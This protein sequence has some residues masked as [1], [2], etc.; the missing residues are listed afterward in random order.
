[1]SLEVGLSTL[2]LIVFVSGVFSS[3][4]ARRCAGMIAAAGLLVLIAA[5]FLLPPAGP[6]AGGVFVDDGLA[7]FAKRLFLVSTFIGVLASLSLAAE[8]FSRR[9]TEYYLLM[10]SSLLGMMVLASARDLI[11][12]FV[13][14][15]LMS[16][17]LY[18][19][20]G[21]LK[22]EPE[23]IEAALKFFLVG[24]VSSAVMAYGLSFVYGIAGTT[25][26]PGVA[27]ALGSE[28]PLLVFGLAAVLAGFGFK[29][30]AFPFHMWVPDTYEAASTPFVAWLS[31]APKAA[32]FVAIF[33]VYLEGVG[34]RAT[35]WL[36]AAA[37]LAAVTIVGGNL[38]ALPQQNVKRLLAYS[39]IAHIGYML[40]GFAAVSASGTAM[41]L[42][43][44]VVYVFGNMGAF[45]VVEAVA[46]SEG[47]EHLGAFRG[48]AQR[49]PL[50]A[51]AMLLFLLSLGGIPFVAGFWAKL[52][53]L[54]AAAQAGLYWLVL[55]GA[56]LTVVALFYYLTIARRMYVEAPARPEPIRLHPTLALCVI[57]CALGVVVLGVYPTPLV[58]AALR[59]AAPLF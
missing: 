54:W 10:L 34:D 6:G 20:S 47:A 35:L 43:Y 48:L 17:P 36:P 45:L 3:G 31:V 29:I 58:L 8:V 1:M 40:V 13:A 30:A 51:L 41:V 28:P 44:L 4:T 33:R 53:V 7:R 46:R 27:K 19:L 5:S 18:V 55:L 49:S 23:A 12:L 14:F 22:R 38:M 56:I 25:S 57:L 50:L 24:S 16:V 52:Y 26:L 32:G 2:M 9:A 39:G 59:A 21:F 11:L 15:E 37:G 42:F